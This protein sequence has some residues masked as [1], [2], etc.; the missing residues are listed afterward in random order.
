MFGLFNKCH[1][2]IAYTQIFKWDGL[3]VKSTQYTLTALKWLILVNHRSMDHSAKIRLH[4]EG[5][6]IYRNGINHI[7]SHKGVKN[8]IYV[9]IFH[10]LGRYL[11]IWRPQH[12][13]WIKFSASRKKKVIFLAYAMLLIRPTMPIFKLELL[14]TGLK[15]LGV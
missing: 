11:T 6:Q 3:T 9:T 14:I 7:V 10:N 12:V 8:G 4:L 5:F 15:M 1:L 13:I 2:L